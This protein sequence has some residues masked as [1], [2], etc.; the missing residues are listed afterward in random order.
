MPK[1][2]DSRPAPHGEPG[3]WDYRIVDQDRRKHNNE[4]KHEPRFMLAEVFFD[5]EGFAV[6]HCGIDI[7]GDSL[8]EIRENALAAVGA[9]EKAIIRESEM[10]VGSLGQRVV[11]SGSLPPPKKKKRMRDHSGTS[12]RREKQ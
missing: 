11:A 1:K 5:E 10:R 9:F 7:D 3:C 6:G 12:R 4:R 2:Q 8:N